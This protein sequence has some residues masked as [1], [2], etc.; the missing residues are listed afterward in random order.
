[1][2]NTSRAARG[3]GLTT[4]GQRVVG[5]TAVPRARAAVPRPS[6]R[7]YRPRR[8]SEYERALRHIASSSRGKRS[9]NPKIL[10]LLAKIKDAVQK[11]R[12]RRVKKS[13]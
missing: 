10:Q 7:T 12:Q 2:G 9:N 6:T 11:L 13:P 5:R 1:M 8:A 4:T 3:R